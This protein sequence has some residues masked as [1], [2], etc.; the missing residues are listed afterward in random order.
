MIAIGTKGRADVI[1]ND[2][3]TAK[4]AG[5]GDLMV[6]STP[7]M[8]ALMEKASH[9]SIAPFLDESQGSVGTHLDVK[10]LAATPLGKNVYAESEVTFAD[11]RKVSFKVSAYDET[12]L[13]GEGTHQRAIITKDR[14]MKKCSER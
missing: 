10:H 11:E 5:S 13:I 3:N 1:V 2:N 8:I 7:S 12:G 6:F 14:F 9:D 4:A